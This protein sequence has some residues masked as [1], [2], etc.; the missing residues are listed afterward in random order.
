M[1]L[2]CSFEFVEVGDETVA[3]PVGENAKSVNG[4]LKLN[5]EGREI[6]SMLEKETSEAEIVDILAGKYK[7]S[8]ESLA[9]YV[10]NLLETLRSYGLITE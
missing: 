7:N 6:F 1:K 4:V 2:K 10:R 3:V 8:R 9:A 5:K